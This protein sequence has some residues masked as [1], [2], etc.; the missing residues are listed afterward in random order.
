VP[1]KHVVVPLTP[2]LFEPW[3]ALFAAAGS[4]CF[5]RYWHFHGTKNEWLA[6]LASQPEEN[7]AEQEKALRE[8][9]PTATGL[10]ALEEER[11]IGW[12]KLAPRSAVPKLARL[13]VYRPLALSLADD[14]LSIACL[15]VHPA[16]RRQGVARALVEAAKATAERTG[17]RSLEAYPHN[18]GEVLREE[19]LWMGPLPLLFEAG[20]HTFE[21]DSPG[22]N[23]A[24]PVLEWRKQ[25][26]E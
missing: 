5:C 4:G 15:L 25:R 11:V 10:I 3:R 17:A 21:A 26:A 24:Y 6:R 9:S 19:E 20:F 23:E 12:L 16:H 22:G 8:G 1:P 7:A 13:P 2:E 14:V 18:R